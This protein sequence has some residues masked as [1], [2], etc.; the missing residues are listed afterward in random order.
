M[1]LGSSSGGGGHRRAARAAR[2]L[3]LLLDNGVVVD[4][5]S[6]AAILLARAVAQRGAAAGREEGGSV[7]S[8]GWRASFGGRGRHFSSLPTA[9]QASQRAEQEQ[10]VPPHLSCAS[11]WNSDRWLLRKE[12]IVS[13]T[14][15]SGMLSCGEWEGGFRREARVTG[16][17]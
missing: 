17:E 7:G 11:A 3:L 1:E 8:G 6:R 9:R 5:N 2:L 15:S 13:A 12:R 14:S 16:S 10:A 4:A